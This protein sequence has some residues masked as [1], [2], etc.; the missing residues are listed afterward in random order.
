MFSRKLF[1]CVAALP[2]VLA[3]V[4]FTSPSAGLTITGTTISV[5]WKES[6]VSPPISDLA[7]YQV[8]LCAGGNTATDYIP[9]TTL[10]TTGDFSTGNSVSA[11][12]TIGLGTPRVNAYFLKTISAADGGVIINYS[13]RFTLT[14]MDGILPAAVTAGLQTVNS[15]SGPPTENDIKSPQK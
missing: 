2:L 6:G 10:V 15:T 9:L 4:K 11:A 14:S 8:F 1:L 5:A 13:G 3:D 12:F 7:E